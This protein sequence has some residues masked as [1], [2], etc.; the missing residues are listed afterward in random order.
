MARRAA[1]TPPSGTREPDD[2]EQTVDTAPYTA[3]EAPASAPSSSAVSA[4][5]TNEGGPVAATGAPSAS[6]RI[7]PQVVSALLAGKR[8]GIIGAG[9]MGGAMCRGLIHANAAD[10]KR[11]VVSRCAS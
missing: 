6:K 2:G 5:A 9:A 8:I 10:P 4:A 3:P 11:I 1:D 7:A